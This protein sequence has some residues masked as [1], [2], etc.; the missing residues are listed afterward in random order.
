M[1]SSFLDRSMDT[2]NFNNSEFLLFDFGIPTEPMF[3]DKKIE[4]PILIFKSLIAFSSSK[5]VK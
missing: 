2:I 1:N 3:V 4:S 5:K